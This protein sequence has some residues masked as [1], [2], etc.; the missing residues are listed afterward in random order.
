MMRW[1]PFVKKPP[2]VAVVR[3]SGAIAA[4]SRLGSGLN[5][6]AMAPVLDRAF[7][8]GKPDAVALVINSPGG[9]PSQSSLIAGRIRRLAE[10][11]ER[12]VYAFVEDLAASGG[13]YIASAADEIWL[14]DNSIIGSIGV[15]SAG[16]GFPD[17][18]ARY[19][20]ERRVH[21]AGKSKS[22]LDPFQPEKDEDV[23]RL[24]QLQEQ[25]HATFIEHVKTRRGA[26]LDSE[27]E[28]FTGDVWV[29]SEA[30][31]LGLADGVAHLV[32]KMKEVFGDKTRFA[33]HGARRGLIPRL[34]TRVVADIADEVESRVL[35]ARYGL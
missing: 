1:I 6:Q 16:F 7:R 27:T 22:L 32:P 29:G 21:T 12:P 24:T 11:H 35:W 10:E 19:G 25:V 2:L 33:V 14:D 8:R 4:G 15:I 31:K 20:I 28:L 18:I 23:A 5:D 3:L 34:G 17:F 26:K 9:S 13:Y 30:V